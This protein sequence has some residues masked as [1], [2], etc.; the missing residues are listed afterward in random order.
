[1]D[2]R[3][4]ADILRFGGFRFDRRRGGCLFRLDSAG[5]AEPVRLGRRALA[6]LGLLL[7]RRGELLS[8]D[9]I[10][11]TVW[12]RRVVEEANLNVQIA[13]L[14]Q[15][16]DEGRE[17]GSYVQTVHGYGYRFVA[18]VRPESAPLIP[19]PAD[20]GVPPHPQRLIVVLSIVALG[21]DGSRQYFANRISGD[22]VI[23]LSRITDILGI[24]PNTATILRSRCRS[25]APRGPTAQAT[26]SPMRWHPL[27]TIKKIGPV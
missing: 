4:S 8:K 27:E 26:S 19:A 20:D 17:R 10:M 15:I 9:E 24:P 21:A 3:G 18:P 2:E 12:P 7:E 1:M 13:H 25:V 16:F 5:I 6:L 14:R 11:K 22:L 23:D